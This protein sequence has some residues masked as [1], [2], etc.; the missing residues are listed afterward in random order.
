MQETI[1]KGAKA[2]EI[3]QGYTMFY[4]G[5]NTNTNGVVIVVGEKWRDN[6]LEVNLISNRFIT[7]KLLIYAININIVS[8]YAPQ[9]GCKYKEKEKFWK[10]IEELIRSFSE[11]D[12]VIIRAVRNGHIGR[13][14][15]GYER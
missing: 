2:R 3:G 14:N 9:A 5:Y 8:A 13:G 15:T 12:N 10:E 6:I 1:W 7:S 11:K 4:N